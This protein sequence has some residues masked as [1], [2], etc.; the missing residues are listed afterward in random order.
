[1]FADCELLEAP[2]GSQQRASPAR[3][4]GA[5]HRHRL[6][7]TE[8]RIPGR[9]DHLFLLLWRIAMESASEERRR[10]NETVKNLHDR[11]IALE[12]KY[13]ALESQKLNDRLIAAE[14]QRLDDRLVAIDTKFSSLAGRLAAFEGQKLND[15]LAAFEGQKLNDRLT[16]GEARYGALDDRLAAVEGQKLDDR[17]AAVEGHKFDNRLTTMENRY[18]AINDRLAAVEGHKSD[19][20]LTTME[21]RYTA[22]NDRLTAVEG[23][24]S[25]NR[26]TTMENR[27]VALEG[28]KLNDRLTSVEG[29]HST[30]ETNVGFYLK[31]GIFCAVALFGL[32]G[33]VNYDIIPS[34]AEENVNKKI[35]EAIDR[36]HLPSLV[37][38]AVKPQLDAQIGIMPGR[39]EQS[40]AKS[41]AKTVKDAVDVMMKNEGR[42]LISGEVLQAVKG[43]AANDLITQLQDAQKVASDAQRVA[44]EAVPVIQDAKKQAEGFQ[45]KL[46]DTNGAIQKMSLEGQKLNDRLTAFEKRKLDDRLSAVESQGLNARLTAFESERL[47]A[48][49]TA[50]EDQGLDDRLTAF[51]KR[52]LDDR[53]S[54]VESQ[55]LNARLTAFERHKPVDPL[56]T[57]GILESKG[58][59]YWYVGIGCFAVLFILIAAMAVPVIKAVKI[60]LES[61]KLNDRLTAFESQKLDDRLS[62]VEMKEKCRRARSP[63]W[64]SFVP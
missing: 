57:L 35:G 23:H 16:T 61:Q 38:N 36:L 33:V 28:Q 40:I 44:S 24:K 45:K 30:M 2:D 4:G 29:K 58:T 59:W 54:A 55:G 12:T 39:V 3:N 21:N 31:A 22:I 46:E 37:E 10:L 6:E 32:M 7:S 41:L 64:A 42:K 13:A 25:D 62:A 56:T 60:S 8:G 51:E 14:S 34:A 48:R 53:L 9:S 52:K 49:L 63:A 17:L 11:L 19:N 50:F 18:T 1:M 15:R 26:L 27:Y 20:R 5:P 43:T 47:N